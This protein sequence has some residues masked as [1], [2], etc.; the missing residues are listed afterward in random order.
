MKTYLLIFCTI[1]FLSCSKQ[2]D[3]SNNDMIYGKIVGYLKCSDSEMQNTLFGIFII[4]NNKDSLLSFNVPSSIYDLDRSGFNKG[5]GFLDGDSVQFCYRNADVD[6]R[7]QF[8]CPPT[9]MMNPTFYSI[10]NFTQ[11]IITDIKKIQEP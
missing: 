4:S 1:L 9:T 5:I 3:S 6:E 11:V 8:D 7:K 2:E 10:D